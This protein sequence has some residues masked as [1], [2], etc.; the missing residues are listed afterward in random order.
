M[1]AWHA[2]GVAVLD[3]PHHQAQH[4]W[5]VRSAVDQ[6]A[7]KYRATTCRVPSSGGPATLVGCGL[8]AESDQQP[9]KLA[10]AAVHVADHVKWP[11]LVPQ[12]IEQPGPRDQCDI[13]FG[14]RPEHVDPAKALPLQSAQAPPEL[15]ALPADDLRPEHAVRPGRVPARADLLWQVEHD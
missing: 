3:H 7:E 6:V 11:G 13:D 5:R 14:L 2:E 1:I 9:L 10:Q 15:V 12:V 8:V 4:S